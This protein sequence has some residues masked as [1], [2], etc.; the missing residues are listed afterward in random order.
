M[1]S[2]L[3]RLRRPSGL[4]PSPTAAGRRPHGKMGAA[5]KAIY[6]RA[7]PPHTARAAKTAGASSCPPGPSAGVCRCFWRR[8]QPRASTPAGARSRVK[9]PAARAVAR[10]PSHAPLPVAS[11][12]GHGGPAA[13]DRLR[14]IGIAGTVLLVP[15]SLIARMGR[16]ESPSA[17]AR[18]VPSRPTDSLARRPNV[19]AACDP[20]AA[21]SPPS[22]CGRV[23]VCTARPPAQELARRL[24]ALRLSR[25]A[26]RA[27]A[28]CPGP[29]K[30]IARLTSG[31]AA[32]WLAASRPLVH[33]S[34]VWILKAGR[35]RRSSGPSRRRPHPAA[36][37]PEHAP[38]VTKRGGWHSSSHYG[39]TRIEHLQQRTQCHRWPPTRCFSVALLGKPMSDYE[40]AT[41]R[42]SP[43]RIVCL[44]WPANAWKCGALQYFCIHSH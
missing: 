42:P 31:T 44:L 15:S 19:L 36:A 12:T 25:R 20:Q 14:R 5:H 10:P 17:D 23:G 8:R 41:A 11:S 21:A 16:D 33:R 43:T 32:A 30:P 4:L 13:A 28:P 39:A 2:S 18:S 7:R 6:P 1:S 29:G 22:P 40:R 24:V 34:P 35:V 37:L 27:A 38:S 9:K 26:R 3:P